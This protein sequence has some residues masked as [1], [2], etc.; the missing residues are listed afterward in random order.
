MEEGTTG[1]TPKNPPFLRNPKKWSKLP[2]FHKGGPLRAYKPPEKVTFLYNY[3]GWFLVSESGKSF[4]LASIL[5]RYEVPTQFWNL[6][7]IISYCEWVGAILRIPTE[8]S[9]IITGKVF[10]NQNQH[11]K[12]TNTH[13]TVWWKIQLQIQIP[14]WQSGGYVHTWSSWRW[15]TGDEGSFKVSWS[16]WIAVVVIISIFVPHTAW[17]EPIQ[18]L[19]FHILCILHFII[20]FCISVFVHLG[21][22]FLGQSVVIIL[23]M[24][25]KF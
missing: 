15:K 2:N 18:C 12:L 23:R 19:Y 21:V 22:P 20:F 4:C 9:L 7:P 13:S 24:H 25:G 8:I 5:V 16:V 10:S 3:F 17:I 1:F 14:T 6:L 11:Q